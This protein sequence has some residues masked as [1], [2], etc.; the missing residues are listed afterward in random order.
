MEPTPNPQRAVPSKRVL[1]ETWGCQMNV[2]DSE[3][4]LQLLAQDGYTPT[5][6]LEDA[7]LVVLNTCHI[8]EKATHKIMSRLGVLREHKIAARPDLQVAVTGCVAQAEGARLFARSSAID[9]LVGPGKIRDLPSLLRAHASSQPRMS[10]GFDRHLATDHEPFPHV[11]S[12]VH[13]DGSSGV[14]KFVTIMQG[15][16]NFCT[17]CVV[18]HTRGREVSR[19]PTT[20]LNEVERWVGQGA[21]EIT[22]LG[23]NVN[24]YGLDLLREQGIEAHADEIPF[25]SHL[26]RPILERNLV[27]RLRFTTSNPHD[28][29]PQLARLFGKYP[30]LGRYV[31]LPVQSGSNKVLERMRRKVTR[32]QYLTTVSMLRQAVPDIAISTDII[33]GFPGET[34][35]DFTDTL[36][37]VREVGFAF[38][39]SFAYS[40]RKHTPAARFRDQVPDA[41]KMRR[42]RELQ[43]IQDQVTTDLHQREVG[44]VREVL[45]HYTSQKNPGWVYGRTEHFHLVRVEGGPSLV[46]RTLP[47]MITAANKTALMGRLD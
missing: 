21:Q 17:F 29:Q 25:V 13:L 15:C 4:M 46:G 9:V 31:H 23:Q 40:P 30:A 42:L 18:P 22:L 20:I 27:R 10:L 37:L 36:E 8:R 39:F 2:A 6:E 33:V 7:D 5:Q 24:S 34:D 47:V 28:F 35:E 1:I 43:A 32:E 45:F 26:L 11:A 3:A 19:P 44:V 38:S 12:T 16:D 14:S 41:I